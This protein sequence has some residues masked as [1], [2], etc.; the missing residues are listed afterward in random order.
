[1]P[2]DLTLI[3]SELSGFYAQLLAVAVGLA[4]AL[5]LRHDLLRLVRARNVVLGGY[6]S[7]YLLEALMIPEALTVGYTQAEYDFGILLLSISISCFLLGYHKLPPYRRIDSMA[8]RLSLLEQPRHLWAVTV[9]AAFIGLAPV[10]YYGGLNL[11]STV[12]GFMGMRRTWG[13]SIGR[14]QFGQVRDAML[15]LELFLI[16]LAGL[17]TVYALRRDQPIWKRCF[18]ALVVTYALLRA[19]GSGTRSSLIIT[20]IPIAMAVV[21]RLPLHYRRRLIL[22]MVPLGFVFYEY[23]VAVVAGREQGVLAWGA[24]TQYVGFEMFRELLFITKYFPDTYD[25]VW[26]ESYIAELV[27]PFPRF[28]WEGK[29]PRFGV[30]YAAIVAPGSVGTGYTAAYGIVGEMYMN[31]GIAGILL[32]SAVGGWICRT[33]DRLGEVAFQYITVM[34]FY[35]MGLAGF[36]VIGRSF[37]FPVFYQA[38]FVFLAV[39]VV[40][41]KEY[42][43]RMAAWR[44]GG[45]ITPQRS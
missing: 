2:D 8:I 26:G 39:I 19:Y 9:S 30:T 36:F 15:M 11:I 38:I 44:A 33:W 14:A 42:S 29:P 20:L 35:A 45:P 4:L 22:L 21:W 7:W 6:L 12:R 41:Q 1:M 32:V 40:T 34:T 16:G 5:D 28:L 27:N 3:G 23:S 17:A 18:A 37:T 10:L 31:F 25:F 24:E 43:Q 13:G